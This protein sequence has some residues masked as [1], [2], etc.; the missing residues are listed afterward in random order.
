[1]TERSEY[2][3]LIV[4]GGMVAD[5]AA[6]GIREKD[7]A[8]SIGILTEEPTGPYERPPLSK[9]L[10]LDPETS[11]EDILADTAEATGAEL[12]T[13]ITVASL[14][15]QRQEVVLASGERV[16]Y[17]KLL[18]ATG[19][20]PQS[21]EAPEDERILAFRTLE[22]YRAL[23][24][25]AGT[26]QKIAVVG[27]GYIGGELAAVLSQ[28]GVE[29]DLVTPETMMGERQL[30]ADLAR[31]Y[32]AL[33]EEH[34]V[35]VHGGRRAQK[36]QRAQDG[37][38][39]VLLDDGSVV[40]TQ[41][42]VLGLG[43][44]PRTELAEAAGLE[45]ADEGVRVGS[46]LRTSDPRVWAAG[47]IASYPD[48]VLGRT[49]IEHVDNARHMG[50]TAGHSMAVDG[51]DYAHTPYFYTMVFGLRWEAVGEL[52]PERE[53]LEV[54]LDEE[55]TVAYYLD[56]ERRPVGVLLWQVEGARD[57]AREVLANPPA[58]PEELRNRIS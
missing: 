32:H 6:R 21:I 7:P 39:S 12:R 35:H 10:W 4:G 42:V 52:D 48:V 51:E 22:D 24:T 13:E 30:P 11:V 14:D 34:G 47:D 27:G 25:L 43:S 15:R 55:R 8:G 1:M 31:R 49:R 40:P 16:G 5:A 46:D 18:L 45:L 58:D 9:L 41:A 19:A 50:Q 53:I 3:Y 26:V 17:Q 54:A 28:E 23:R 37:S 56:A 20:A 44:V 57:A 38:L 33:F 2:Q 36:V 29:V